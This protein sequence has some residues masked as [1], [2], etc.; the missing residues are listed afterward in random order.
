NFSAHQL[1]PPCSSVLQQL[2]QEYEAQDKANAFQNSLQ[3]KYRVT[4]ISNIYL[5]IEVL[6]RKQGDAEIDYLLQHPNA[7]ELVIQL[8]RLNNTLQQLEISLRQLLDEYAHKSIFQVQD[9]IASISNNA[10]ALKEVLP[11][12]RQFAKLPPGIQAI[13]RKLPLSPQQAQAAMAWKTWGLLLQQHPVFARTNDQAIHDIYTTIEKTYKELLQ[14]N[15]D[16]IRAARRQRFLQ[17]Y[18][19][20]NTAAGLLTPEQKLLKKEYQEGRR[21]LEHEMGKT[22]SYKSI[23]E[24]ASDE[25]GK[26]LKDVKPVWLMSPL[27]VSDSLALDTHFFDVVIFDEASQITL[28]EGIPALFR[29]PQTIIV[30]D[31]K[32]M[33]PSNF[34]NAK[35]EDPNDLENFEGESEDEILSTEA[36]SLLVQGSRKLHSTMLS[37]HYRSRYE[38]LISYSNHAFY[39]A[40]LLTIPDKTI[41]HNDRPGIEVHKPEEGVQNAAQL[42]H[43]SISFHYLPASVYEA[44]GNTG[45]ARY[46]AYMIRELLLQNIPETI[47]IVAFSQEQ[48]G[49]IEDSIQ[50][51][52]DTDKI[53]DEALEKAYNRKDEGQFTGLFVK[54][55]ENVQGDERD[56]IIMSVCYGH[57]AQHKMLMNFGPINRKGGEKRLNVLFS[58]AR[59]HMAIVSSIRQQHITNDYNE[60]ANYLKRFLHYAEMVSIGNMRMAR[61]ILDSLVTRDTEEAAAPLPVLAYTITQI[62]TALEAAG[63]WVDE[64]IGQSSFK[65]SLGIKKNPDDALYSL[66]VLVD[67][68]R[69]YDNDNLVEQYY[70][71]PAMLR[72]F[73][74]Q[75]KMVFAKDWMEDPQRV[76]AGLLKALDGGAGAKEATLPVDTAAP[77]PPPPGV[78]TLVSANGQLFWEIKQEGARL[79]I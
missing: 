78:T 19:L 65:C 37:W 52:A 72:A 14:L 74:W 57:D 9:E 62:K 30:G 49:I 32:Q 39:E 5:G 8:S 48:Q 36:D 54:N 43:N 77:A 11:A 28:E 60:G 66:G 59:K 53:F 56:I 58:R 67:D 47:G 38:T 31:D 35:T 27:S 76:L 40:G 12:L 69:H 13:I 71:R 68:E 2:Q 18:D 42:L 7:N 4:N 23:R 1:A 20:S 22:R 26:V 34:F 44:R 50:Q 51:L 61:T 29:A 24:M 45:E 75:V 64:L 10:E 3:E 15:S 55:L 46:I 6:R 16:Y 33:P 79:L 63:Y 25:S 21:V 17:S 70:Q 73:G 41:H